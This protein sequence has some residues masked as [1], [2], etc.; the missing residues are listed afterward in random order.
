MSRFEKRECADGSFTFY[1]SDVGEAYHAP[2]GAALEAR[3]KY[4]AAC[5]IP[6][7]CA[8][9]GV[10]R[11]LDVCFGLGYNSAAALELVP[12]GFP[13]QVIGL[14]LDALIIRE[15]SSLPFPFDSGESLFRSLALAEV[16]DG[17][18]E[19]HEGSVDL[20]VLVGD[21][22]RRV[23]DVH[24]GWADV[25]FFDPF[26]PKKAPLL[27][28]VDFFRSVFAKCASGA[29]LVTY[30]CARLVRENL[31]AAGFV[32]EDGPVVGRRGPATVGRKP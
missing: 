12:V 13:V 2:V 30:S 19:V 7:L 28:T 31:V 32:V 6:G 4:V 26:S 16:V 15:S 22:T 27:W 5:G 23:L 18:L 1:N 20:R 21:A 24:D 9:K 17:Q 11:I 3:E 8:R 29:V 25:I 10:L 14:E